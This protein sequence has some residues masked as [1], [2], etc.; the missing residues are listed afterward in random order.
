MR[1]LI[2]ISS[3]LILL[4]TLVAGAEGAQISAGAS[5]KKEKATQKVGSVTFTCVKVKNKLIWRSQAPKTT[6]QTTNNNPNAG[7]KYVIGWLCDGIT[8]A[9]GAK[10]SNGV[11]MVCIQGGDGKFAWIG[12]KS[13][14]D[15]NQLH[16]RLTQIRIQSQ[17]HQRMD[18]HATRLGKNS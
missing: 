16:L 4:L 12:R 3:T 7:K 2:G 5:C 14:N 10:D 8:D 18:C 9:K 13:T 17:Q 15:Q 6:T 11:E 1:R